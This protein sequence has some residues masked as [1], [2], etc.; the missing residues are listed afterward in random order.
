M[1][2]ECWQKAQADLKRR[3][4]QHAA[5]LAERSN[6]A[7][8]LQRV[9][10][11]YGA[12]LKPAQDAAGAALGTAAGSSAAGAASGA[13]AEHSSPP[14]GELSPTATFVKQ[15]DGDTRDDAGMQPVSGNMLALAQ[16]LRKGRMP[17]RRATV[18]GSGPAGGAA[19]ARGLQSLGR[20]AA[21]R[22]SNGAARAGS[23]QAYTASAIGAAGSNACRNNG[24][25]EGS[26]SLLMQAAAHGRKHARQSDPAPLHARALRSRG[27]APEIAE[28]LNAHGVALRD[29]TFGFKQQSPD[30]AVMVLQMEVPALCAR[31]QKQADG[32]L[33]YDIKVPPGTFE[34]Q[35]DKPLYV[36]AT[37]VARKLTQQAP[38]RTDE[39]CKRQFACQRIESRCFMLPT[40]EALAGVVKH[41]HAAAN[42]SCDALPGHW[43]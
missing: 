17:A 18:H 37:D 32:T 14:T 40:G 28:E 25:R 34:G 23:E 42:A 38:E 26:P 27:A 22:A 2:Q 10:Q 43:N 1:Q 16:S 15:Q 24:K 7:R 31:F 12:V 19:A 4:E 8:L 5:L 6:L 41:L 20:A 13:R 39:R 29:L 33:T 36:Q 3:Q 9:E 35:P 11:R 30:A 21:H